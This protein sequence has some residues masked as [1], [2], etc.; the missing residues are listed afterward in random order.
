MPKIDNRNKRESIP[1]ITREWVLIHLSSYSK[2]QDDRL[3]PVEAS[4]SGICEE[5]D[6]SQSALSEALHEIISKG[7]IEEEKRYVKGFPDRRKVYFLTKKGVEEKDRLM[8]GLTKLKVKVRNDAGYLV[9]ISLGDVSRHLGRKYSLMEIARN[10]TLERVVNIKA[11]EE[12]VTK[13]REEFFA[14]RD[15]SNTLP[16]AKPLF[17]REKEIKELGDWSNDSSSPVLVLTGIGGSGKTQLVSN[18]ISNSLDES[19]VLW[20]R[21]L[22]WSAEQAILD[23]L[24]YHLTRKGKPTLQMYLKSSSGKTSLK[25]LK[26]ILSEEL[27]DE[28]TLFVFDDV[29]LASEEI[30]QFISS[31]IEIMI[32]GN[33]AKCILIGR[34]RPDFL[35][36]SDF[37]NGKTL[38]EMSLE[39]L[40]ELAS[41]H[42]L[43][44]LGIED[45]DVGHIYSR[46]LGHPLSMELIGSS[47]VKMNLP[48][49]KGTGEVDMSE[50]V[51][52]IQR[53][54]IEELS[55]EERQ[56]L[57]VASVFRYPVYPDAF[58]KDIVV[59]DEILDLL[60][61]K[62]LLRGYASNVFDLHDTLK[63]YLLDRIP[64]NRKASYH[65]RAVEYFRQDESIQSEIEILHHLLEMGEPIQACMIL[66][67]EKDKLINSIYLQALQEI[68]ERPAWNDLDI[69]ESVEV[70]LIRID[71]L[72]HRGDWLRA[73]KMIADALEEANS[74]DL[75]AHEI[76]CK[77]S[78]MRCDHCQ[79]RWEDCILI[80][81]EI[82]PNAK[83]L[84]LLDVIANANYW[85]GASLS[86]S[87]K[88]SE[89]IDAMKEGLEASE[90]LG[91]KDLILRCKTG[92]S[93]TLNYMGDFPSCMSNWAEMMKDIVRRRN[94]YQLCVSHNNQGYQY[95][96][97]G[98]YDESLHNLHKAYKIARM[99][100]LNHVL[101][102]AQINIS[103]I[104]AKRG[105]LVRA[106]RACL[107]A[108]P[109][110]EQLG[111]NDPIAS[112]NLT[113]GVIWTRLQ[114]WDVAENY[115]LKSIEIFDT[116]G[117]PHEMAR[118]Y[119]EYAQMS[120]YRGDLS[121]ARKQLIKS[122]EIFQRLGNEY[123]IEEM[124]RALMD[125][126]K[127]SVSENRINLDHAW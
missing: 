84:N 31:F 60:V 103:F 98:Q 57:E 116:L 78:Q 1:L 14:P 67:K 80:G 24:G 22:D 113:R 120:M 124:E 52:F 75:G 35:L 96:L 125:L 109:L 5:L 73:R 114:S 69:P 34:M 118:A 85:M 94:I 68:L 50:M 42:F 101:V 112:I 54:I 102:T 12:L 3:I 53:E 10:I 65:G 90:T 74:N 2:F 4:Q 39:N 7:F 106:E 47:N 36:P 91:D 83:A 44:S 89:A 8:N 55:P 127:W 23:S 115:F 110:V 61:K 58:F 27:M 11:L 77:V 66:K 28:Q 63:S 29:H 38:K 95:I 100:G 30:S 93:A 72:M 71:G 13:R 43:G 64:L 108:E 88:L 18:Y 20:Q 121:G 19:D 87:G 105:D 48:M 26:S 107:E 76:R 33:K 97:T 41:H 49:I 16:K 104:H 99:I 9:E 117:I 59:D 40:D 32:E 15:F 119:Y 111:Y 17:G 46:T 86:K 126:D 82:I 81:E 51:K 62:T 25:E 79:E 70:S 45:E 122:R 56:V 123:K 92:L 37:E 21:L 6:L